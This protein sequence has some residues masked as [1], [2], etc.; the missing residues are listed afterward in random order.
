MTTKILALTDALGNLVRFVLMPGHRIL[1]VTCEKR[2]ISFLA[3]SGTCEAQEPV[4]QPPI[5]PIGSGWRASRPV[6]SGL[7]T[8]FGDEGEVGLGHFY[9][10]F[11]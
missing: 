9:L 6:Q 8:M 11:S 10:S 2:I 1:I 3:A 5:K 4:A 7:R